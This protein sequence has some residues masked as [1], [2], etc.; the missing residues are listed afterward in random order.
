MRSVFTLVVRDKGDLNRTWSSPLP[1]EGRQH[2]PC[3]VPTLLPTFFILFQAER[4]LHSAGS[5]PASRRPQEDH[6]SSYWGHISR[7]PVE[8]CCWGDMCLCSSAR[9]GGHHLWEAHSGFLFL[10]WYGVFGVNTLLLILVHDG[11]QGN[12]KF[13][14]VFDL[15]N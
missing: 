6:E 15:S 7:F 2:T 3:G 13:F 11:K 4:C 1:T 14:P 9:K 10:L 5:A 8:L 12:A